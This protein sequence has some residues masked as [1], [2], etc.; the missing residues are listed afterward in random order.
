MAKL[1]AEELK[2]LPVYDGTTMATAGKE[3][4][5][6]IDK[7]KASGTNKPTWVL[8]GGQRNSPVEYK[9]DSIDGSHKTSG[10]WGEA[11]SGPKSW[12][13]N[14]TGLLIMDD[15]GFSIMEY[16]FH[17]DTPIHVKIAYP[18][19]TCQ[20]G[21]ATITAFTKD[22]AHDGVATVSAT[23]SGKGPISEIAADDSV[24]G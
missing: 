1:T 12:S 10:G 20:I 6:Y 18:D 9:A 5:L 3:T 19:K 13:I 14:Y 22:V 11:L 7:A 23:L 21:W 24:G 17:H 4:L 8:V 16:A 2:K 15:A